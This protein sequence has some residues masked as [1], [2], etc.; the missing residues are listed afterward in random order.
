MRNQIVIL[1]EGGL[2]NEIRGIPEDTD[3]VVID[4]DT[5]GADP[6][7]TTVCQW[8]CGSPIYPAEP[9]CF[10]TV[11]DGP[12]DPMPH[13]DEFPPRTRHTNAEWP[14]EKEAQ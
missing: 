11:W 6:E 13:V 8:P 2:I 4:L 5:E 14:A 9:Q 12:S 1:I 3:I 7:D 10:L